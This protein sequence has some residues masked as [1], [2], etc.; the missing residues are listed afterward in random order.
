MSVT[1]ILDLL[2][3]KTLQFLNCYHTIQLHNQHVWL[4]MQMQVLWI[5]RLMRLMCLLCTKAHMCPTLQ[6]ETDLVK[7]LV[8]VGKDSKVSLH[9]T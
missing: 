5:T 8:I 7:H 2:M 1:R 3:L 9:L 4:Q 6:K